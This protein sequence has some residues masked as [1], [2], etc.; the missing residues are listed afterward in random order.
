[1]HRSV[2]RVLLGL[3]A[4]FLVVIPQ[5]WAQGRSQGSP[6]KQNAKTQMDR[7]NQ[8][9]DN[10]DGTLPIF[11][12]HDRQI[13]IEFYRSQRSNLPPGLAKRNG[14][15]PPGLE[16]HLER[17]GTLP[18]GLQ[19]RVEPLPHELEI[20]LPRLPVIYRRGSIGADVIILNQKTGAVVDIIRDVATITG[21]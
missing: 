2:L 16:R 13:I 20:R 9:E 7:E 18:P 21:R 4:L 1:M 14:N 12:K 8:G 10:D 17:N 19:K 6:Q 15:L 3:L 11:H 5:T